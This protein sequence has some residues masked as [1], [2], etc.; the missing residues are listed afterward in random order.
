MYVYLLYERGRCRAS[1]RDTHA[2]VDEREEIYME[3]KTLA[4][5]HTDY[6]MTWD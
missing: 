2:L 4:I 3:V 5:Q 6:I 1:R